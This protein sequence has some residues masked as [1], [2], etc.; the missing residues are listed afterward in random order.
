MIEF[1]QL[2]PAIRAN[3]AK[4]QVEKAVISRLYLELP[5]TKDVAKEII[6]KN[7]RSLNLRREEIKAEGDIKKQIIKILIWGYPKDTRNTK[8]LLK[9]ENLEKI[10]QAVEKYNPEDNNGKIVLDELLTIKRLGL[11]TASKILY[12]RG[13]KVGNYKAIIIDSRVR[14]GFEYITEFQKLSKTS[15][16]A[17]YYGKALKIVCNLA[18]Q[19]ELDPEDVEYALFKLGEYWGKY[20]TITSESLNKLMKEE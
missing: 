2:V 17:S 9:K 8:I 14:K 19:Y 12:F 16:G 7:N 20:S 5:E 3:S 13:I 1:E 15:E 6:D 4:D 11:S 18:K 10:I